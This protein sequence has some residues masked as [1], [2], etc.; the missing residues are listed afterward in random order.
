MFSHLKVVIIAQYF[1]FSLKFMPVG[2]SGLSLALDAFKGYMMLLIKYPQVIW[3]IYQP[4]VQTNLVTNGFLQKSFIIFPV[5]LSE[6]YSP[7]SHSCS[8]SRLH[9]LCQVPA[10]LQS[11]VEKPDGRQLNFTISCVPHPI[12]ILVFWFKKIFS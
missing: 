6:I 3:V 12:H 7:A 5:L 2:M 10:L 9:L 4:S 8:L 11:A 1:L